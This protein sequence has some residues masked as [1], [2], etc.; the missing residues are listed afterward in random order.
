MKSAVCRN[1]SSSLSCEFGTCLCNVLHASDSLIDGAFRWQAPEV[2][3]GRT[4][5]TTE[6]D[7]YSYAIC[8]IEILTMGGVPWSAIDDNAVRDLVLS[9]S[10]NDFRICITQSLSF[11]I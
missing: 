11:R 10:V 9:K 5:L 3:E 6:S 4:D 8:C 1:T 2:L 7:V